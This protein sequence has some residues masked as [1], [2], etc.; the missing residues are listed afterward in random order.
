MEGATISLTGFKPSEHGDPTEQ[1][2]T[3]AQDDATSGSEC[4]DLLTDVEQIVSEI[5][6][7]SWAHEFPIAGF[8]HSSSQTLTTTCGR[9]RPS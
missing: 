4:N 9:T 3:E 5:K 8:H 2:M 1:A 6:V 7:Y